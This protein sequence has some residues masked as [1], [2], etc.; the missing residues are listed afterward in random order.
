LRI[1]GLINSA[2]VIAVLVVL[3]VQHLLVIL[4]D[5]MG[6]AGASSVT[7]DFAIIRRGLFIFAGLAFWD[8]LSGPLH[9]PFHRVEPYGF[10]AFLG[11]LGYVA[12]RQTLERDQQLGEIQKELEVA[13]RIQL[14]ILPSEFPVSRNF[15]VAARYVPMTS[16]AGD[17]YD[18]L[19][20]NDTQAGLLIADV[21]GHGVPAA[22]IA[23]MVKLAATS[24]RAHAADPAQLL[25]GMNVAL[26]GNTQSQF[27]TAAY[28]H[29]DAEAGELRY[30]AAGHPP[31]L[32]LRNGEARGIEENGLM[33]A[34]FDFAAYSNAAQPLHPGDRLLLYTDGIVEAAN[35][36][37]DFFGAE[38][39]MAEMQKTAR[40]SPG[41]AADSILAA[42]R[43]WSATQDDDWTVLVCDYAGSS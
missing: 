38:A 20:G 11:A 26:C 16:V 28:V 33:L 6:P 23:S 42:I 14:S 29:L 25:T 37:G 1:Y 9:I 31:M 35:A 27:V 21:S 10:V 2:V 13:R 36:D 8:N 4:K 15:R 41:E 43:R 22:L 40:L 17:F 12:A 24:Q 18:F 39:L 7:G 3:V 34:A 19:V 32:L 5:K 30:S